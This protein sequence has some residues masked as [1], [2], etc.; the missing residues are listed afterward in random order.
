MSDNYLDLK[1]KMSEEK[2]ANDERYK[3]YSKDRLCKNIAGK[4]RTTMIGSL[5]IIEQELG[6]LWGLNEDRRL[7]PEEEE[8]L[9]IWEDIRTRILDLGN[10]NIRMAE[11]EIDS[12]TLNWNKF[13]TNLIFN[14]K[15]KD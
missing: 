14:N 6:Y 4:I 8:M 13:K 11:E 9:I 2:R 15:E 5:A 12:Y 10:N 3:Q 7:T 1:R